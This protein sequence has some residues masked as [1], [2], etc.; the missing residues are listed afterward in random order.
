MTPSLASA[1]LA[2]ASMHCN[3][4]TFHLFPIEVLVYFG[5][6]AMKPGSSPTSRR[7]NE[8]GEAVSGFALTTVLV[9][10]PA[11]R[12]RMAGPVME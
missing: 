12:A 9:S 1:K 10:D 2:Q 4:D 5:A 11:A 3:A 6:Q 8:W 7:V